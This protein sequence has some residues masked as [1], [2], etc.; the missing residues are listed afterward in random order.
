MTRKTAEDERRR[1]VA[2]AM[3]STKML[4]CRHAYSFRHY[5][6]PKEHDDIKVCR[7]AMSTIAA[8]TA[9]AAAQAEN[10]RYLRSAAT[11]FHVAGHAIGLRQVVYAEIANRYG[12]AEKL[13]ARTFVQPR[14]RRAV[15]MAC[16]FCC[17][18]NAQCQAQQN[19]SLAQSPACAP[20]ISTFS[21]RAF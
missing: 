20:V 8:A 15:N 3:P 4:T 19:A 12:E 14:I 11:K 21:R 13:Q 16:S 9:T 17:T 6:P 18:T 10:N 1:G 2:G 5:T 7:E